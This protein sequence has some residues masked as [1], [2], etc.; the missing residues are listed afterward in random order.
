MSSHSIIPTIDYSDGAVRIIDQTMLP[1]REEI[2]EITSLEE[3]AE[4]IRTLK[5][6]GAPAIGIAAAYGVLLALEEYLA[7]RIGDRVDCCFDRENG[8]LGGDM[9]GVEATELQKVVDAAAEALAKTR[10]TAVNLSWALERVTE[11]A[12]GSDAAAVCRSVA[13]AAFGIHAE[14]LRIE[15]TIGEYGAAFVTDGMTIL[16]HCNA[17]GLATAGFGT[18][19]AILY[20]AFEDGKRFSVYADETRPLLQGARLTAW[21]LMRRGIDVTVI[22]DSA[23]ASLFAAGR[24]DMVVVGADR[25]ARNGDV[26]N[27][28]G[29]L[30]LALLCEHYERPLYVAAPWSTF[31]IGIANGA[32][33][34]IE[35]RS[36]E[37]VTSLAGVRITPRGTK[38]YN[39][40]FDVTPAR[41]VTAIVTELGVIERPDRR[42]IES[43]G[44]KVK[45]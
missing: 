5:V 44:R 13:E 15:E 6:R 24:I 36:P 38:A 27:K 14:E 21:E 11:S 40:A 30:G 37:E 18:A 16:T 22:C 9:P 19:L 25:I 12:K 41:L 43:F 34:P 3:M 29:T 42:K 20:R 4:A 28:V 8:F 31:D 26:A 1:G 10:P 2:V 17:G 7:E 39:P 33:I 32:S 45:L 35:E 23:A